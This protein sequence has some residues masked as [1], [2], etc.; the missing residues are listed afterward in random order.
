MKNK[1][2]IT[3]STGFV[4]G[5]LL[6]KLS[7]SVLLGRS[8]PPNFEGEYIKRELSS[9]SDFS[10]CFQEIGV[11]IHCA[12]RVHVMNERST[13]PLKAFRE[14]NVEGTL[15]LAKQA[16][17]ASV[18]R[19]IFVS[20][21]KVNGESTQVGSKYTPLGKLNPEDAYGVSKYE[22]E[23][24]L[25]KLS[26]ETGMELVI[27][28]PTLVYGAGVKGNFINLLKLSK[29]MLPLPFGSIHNAR[30]MVYIEN[31]VDLIITC[32]DHTEASGKKFL[33]SDGNDVSLSQ[34]IHL[35]RKSMGK[36][37]LLIPVPTILFKIVGTLTG[38]S[39]V[40]NRLIGN[41][42]VENGDAKKYLNWNPPYTV[43][44]GIKA[45]VDD[46]IGLTDLECNN[47]KNV[48][49]RVL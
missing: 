14:I 28:R 2:L 26:K 29:L 19:F 27:I 44:Q 12:A 23:E 37:S 1:V 9:N 4:G 45:T 5:A 40:I 18:R 34:L 36:P 30:S 10:G 21:I 35:I 31:L 6:R 8:S 41:L 39:S 25:I 32:I 3:G 20:S 38:K 22:A 43:E 13:D 24:Q 49:G 11:V 15:N 48:K 7:N 33:A 46:F 47:T 42:Q 16:A 17:E